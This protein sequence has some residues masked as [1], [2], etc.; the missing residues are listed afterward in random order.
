ML[1]AHGETMGLQ[2]SPWQAVVADSVKEHTCGDVWNVSFS[3][4]WWTSTLP[5]AS[6]IPQLQLSFPH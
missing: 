1:A 5:L 4:S 6:N 2:A 3:Q